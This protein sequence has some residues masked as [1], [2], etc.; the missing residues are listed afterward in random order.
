MNKKILK[1]SLAL[2]FISLLFSVGCKKNVIYDITGLWDFDIMMD[3]GTVFVDTYSFAGSIESGDVFYGDQQLGTYTVFDR[4]VNIT[5][6]YYDEDDDY[7]VE[8]FSG[9]FDD[10]YSMSGNY[11]LYIEGVGTF[12]GTWNA[13]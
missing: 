12:A 5:I 4:G 3:D 2:L 8:T 9:Y 6:A 10:G 1:I 7:T 11:T 13:Q